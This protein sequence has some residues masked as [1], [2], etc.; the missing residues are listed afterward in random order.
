MNVYQKLK[1]CITDLS[2]G[3]DERLALAGAG[4]GSFSIKPERKGICFNM[5]QE[6]GTVIVDVQEREDDATSKDDAK[7]SLVELS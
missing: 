4:G 2:G 5:N 7:I 1:A 3:F 6:L